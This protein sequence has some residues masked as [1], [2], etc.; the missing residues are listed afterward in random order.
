MSREKIDLKKGVFSK[1][2]Y[3]KTIDT[4]FNELGVKTVSEQLQEET[5]IEEF[6][7]LYNEL[8][9]E[10]PSEGEFN[11]HRYIAEQ[12]GE[13]IDFD[14]TIEEVEA[15]R[16]E[17]AILRTDLLAQQIKNI[18]LETGQP[19][20]IN[21]D[22]LKDQLTG[23][24]SNLEANQASLADAQEQSAKATA[25]A[26]RVKKEVDKSSGVGYF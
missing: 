19:L 9:Y 1:P 24:G 7:K 8:F 15:L 26:T 17:I 23:L 6:F 21:T 20:N 2:Q 12:S 3:T 13:Y 5:S 10:I 14:N 25:E 4:Q 22:A 16:Q 18:E 11:S